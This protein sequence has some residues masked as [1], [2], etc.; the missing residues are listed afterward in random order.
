MCVSLGCEES[1]GAG[2]G[3][4]AQS[5]GFL[6]GDLNARIYPSSCSRATETVSDLSNAIVFTSRL[7]LDILD[8]PM[9]VTKTELRKVITKLDDVKLELLRLRAALLPEERMTAG[10]R[11]LMELSRR[12]IEKGR[13]V[14]LLQLR[15]ELGV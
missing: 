3:T 4:F 8:R 6:E 9:A 14:T 10:E 12:E 7:R 2:S 5:R 13:Y 1:V 15:K 11:R